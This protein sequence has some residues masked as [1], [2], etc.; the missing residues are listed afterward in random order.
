V[1]VAL[2][3]VPHHEQDRPPAHQRIGDERLAGQRVQLFGDR[4]DLRYGGGVRLLADAVEPGQIPLSVGVLF[5]ERGR[6]VFD[7]PAQGVFRRQGSLDKLLP[8]SLLSQPVKRRE[9]SPGRLGVDLAFGTKIVKKH[10]PPP[11][12][13]VVDDSQEHRLAEVGLHVPCARLEHLVVDA[14]GFE[15]FLAIQR[16]QRHVRVG[17]PAAA[18]QKR[19]LPPGE[20]EDGRLDDAR[21]TIVA[22]L[23][24][25]EEVLALLVESLSASIAEHLAVVEQLCE[26]PFY[27]LPSLQVAG[28]EIE[29]HPARLLGPRHGRVRGRQPAKPDRQ[30]RTQRRPTQ[31][32]AGHLR[33]SISRF[34]RP[35]EGI[36]CPDRTAFTN[37]SY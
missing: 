18:D 27:H 15:H 9:T 6:K 12:L 16:A 1:V 5:R 22:R 7:R 2:V 24:G 29:H 25:I 4:F 36:G 32:R 17:M 11:L 37:H 23:H 30:Q 26:L 3:L 31:R 10:V 19:D 35:I 33:D 14:L 13:M 34:S 21:L 28:L 20:H 8:L